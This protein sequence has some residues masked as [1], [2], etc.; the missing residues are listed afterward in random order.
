V[1]LVSGD[2]VN[3]F[4]RSSVKTAADACGAPEY[5]GIAMAAVVTLGY[6]W[7]QVAGI[8]P[9]AK[10]KAST[11]YAEGALMKPGA[12]VLDVVTDTEDSGEAVAVVLVGIQSDAVRNRTV[13]RLFGPS[14]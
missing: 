11:A 3:F 6:G 12:G 13:V 5:A 9:A 14:R 7:F 1:A 8:H 2:K 10:V 4:R